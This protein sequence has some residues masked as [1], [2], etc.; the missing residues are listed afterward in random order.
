MD[1]GVEGRCA[2]VC[3]STGG[4][5]EATA[6]ALAAEGA[7]VMVCGRRG[8]RAE[9]IASE[10]PG[11]VAAEV[12]LTAPDGPARLLAAAAAAFD[13]VDVL[14]L[15]GPGPR[16][17][18]ADSLTAEDS[19][20]AVHDLLLIHQQL[21]TALLPGMRRRGWGRIVAIGSSGVVEPLANLARVSRIS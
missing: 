2:L 18:T 16:P 7:R 9:R 3:A 10:L 5:G 19:A 14:V 8:D 20:R 13:Q 1:L 21:V 15:N 6:R 12:D 17:A 4:L 11:A